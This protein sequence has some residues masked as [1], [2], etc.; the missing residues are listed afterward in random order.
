MQNRWHVPSE[1]NDSLFESD[2]VNTV[3]F[4]KELPKIFENIT[5]ESLVDS[6]I[7]FIEYYD[8]S[9]KGISG[10][11]TNIKNELTYIY[12]LRNYIVHDAKLIDSQ[13]PYYANRALFYASSLFNAILAISTSNDIS[14]EDAIIKLFSDCDMFMIEIDELLKSYSLNIK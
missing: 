5:E 11:K 12:R 4:F 1:I 13:L 7:P 3:A 6:L 8:K 9:G 10:F 2:S 14:L